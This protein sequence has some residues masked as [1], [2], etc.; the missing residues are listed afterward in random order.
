MKSPSKI[1]IVGSEKVSRNFW[2]F[3]RNPIIM[4]NKKAQLTIRSKI[5]LALLVIGPLVLWYLSKF[6]FPM[7][8]Y[9][10][11]A[12]V[13]CYLLFRKKEMKKNA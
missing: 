6:F 8:Y 1:Y 2:K 4:N 5:N 12:L 9:F 13:V 3:P 7:P 11:L 10:W